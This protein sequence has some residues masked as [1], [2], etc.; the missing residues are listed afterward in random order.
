M[1]EKEQIEK[2]DRVV[3]EQGTVSYR[4]VSKSH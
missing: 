1:L 4:A 3:E 2:G